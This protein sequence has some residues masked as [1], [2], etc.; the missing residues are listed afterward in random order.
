M[1]RTL[2]LAYDLRTGFSGCSR[3]Q[4]VCH[5]MYCTSSYSR[6]S[7]CMYSKYSILWHTS[8]ELMQNT[9]RRYY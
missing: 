8:Y 1:H 6:R 2:L 5:V 4:S 3:L 9:S 7:T